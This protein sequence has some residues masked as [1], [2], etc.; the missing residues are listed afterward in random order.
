[1][2]SSVSR[3]GTLDA[4]QLLKRIRRKIGFEPPIAHGL[5]SDRAKIVRAVLLF[6]A[7]NLLGTTAITVQVGR[8][9]SLYCRRTDAHLVPELLPNPDKQRGIKDATLI[10]TGTSGV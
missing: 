5:V 7:I 1:M 8:R 4:I 2:E 10:P 3:A 9:F 6:H